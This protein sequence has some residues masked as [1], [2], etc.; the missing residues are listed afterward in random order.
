MSEQAIFWHVELEKMHPAVPLHTAAS[1]KSGQVA[2]WHLW[3][4]EF[5]AH[6]APLTF[7]KLWHP[8]ASVNTE[9]ALVVIVEHAL[10]EM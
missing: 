1:V 5:Q 3:S 6:L 7:G 4:V 9:H 8:A 10:F 2:T